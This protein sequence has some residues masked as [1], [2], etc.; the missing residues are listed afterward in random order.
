MRPSAEFCHRA[1]VVLL[2]RRQSIE[3]NTEEPAVKDFESTARRLLGVGVA[4]RRAGRHVP[5]VLAP[6]LEEVRI[7]LC[8]RDDA[9]EGP[10]VDRQALSLD[11]RCDRAARRW[12][13][14][15]PD[16]R[17]VEQALGIR[18]R[19]S[20]AAAQLRQARAHERNRQLAL[21]RAVQSRDQRRQL[22]FFHVLQLVDEQHE[23]GAGTLRGSAD[24][25]EQR[26][27][28]VLEIAVVG[29]AG[30]GLEIDPDLDIVKLHLQRARETRERP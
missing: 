17:E 8:L 15:R 19:A 22:F 13:R 29:E 18:L 10:F 26:G 3:A 27:Q 16:L 30:L 11:R 7:A 4:N 28:V 6:L 12:F 24:R 21:G 20:H 9:R 14:K 23:R 25:L 1:H 5:R 2:A